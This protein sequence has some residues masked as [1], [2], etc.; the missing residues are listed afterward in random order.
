MTVIILRWIFALP[1]GYLASILVHLLCVFIFGIFEDIG[2][3]GAFSLIESRDMD[4]KPI[5]GTFIVFSA[6]F[7]STAAFMATTVFLVPKYKKQIAVVLG[8]L[9]I[10]GSIGSVMNIME[11]MDRSLNIGEWYR[12]ILECVSRCLGT[13]SGAVAT[14]GYK[15]M[16]VTKK[17]G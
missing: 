6:R 9:V 12:F 13:V 15:N 16:D 8:I 3:E 5:L 1:I 7:S 11:V 17:P 10:I 14:L 2:V 4:G